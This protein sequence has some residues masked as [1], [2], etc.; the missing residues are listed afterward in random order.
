MK[1]SS[2]RRCCPVDIESDGYVPVMARFRDEFEAPPIYWR[3]GDFKKTLVE[4]GVDRNNGAI[5]KITVTS[6]NGVS[7]TTLPKIGFA[8]SDLK[9]GIPCADLEVLGGETRVDVQCV[10]RALLERDELVVR[11]GDSV[12]TIDNSSRCGNVAFLVSAANEV[13]GVGFCSFTD[14]Q[15]DNLRFSS[16]ELFVRTKGSGP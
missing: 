12:P 16:G 9:E 5:C 11:F 10:V 1:M 3:T 14:E 15:I 7:D 8:L 13:C 4:I 6:I 2:L